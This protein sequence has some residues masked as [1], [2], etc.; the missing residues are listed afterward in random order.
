MVSRRA[1]SLLVV[2]A[3]VV[4]TAVA[5][6]IMSALDRDAPGA[7]VVFTETVPELLRRGLALSPDGTRLIYLARTAGQDLVHVRPLAQRLATPIRDLT[8]YPRRPFVSPS[9][10][11]LGY[12]NGIRSIRKVSMQGGPFVEILD[13]MGAEERGASWGADD[14]IIAERVGT[15]WCDPGRRGR[16]A[17]G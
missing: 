2:A 1:A 14:R 8:N 5:V 10:D 13:L 9:G 17:S 3:M 6:T 15:T 7:P 4:G 16:P 12:F 11:W